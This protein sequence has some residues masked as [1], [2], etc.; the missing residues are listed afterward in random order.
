MEIKFPV[1]EGFNA[2]DGVAEGEKFEFMAEGYFSGS[3]MYLTAVEG[4]PVGGEPEAEP[5]PEDM[6]SQDDRGFVDSV[7]TGLA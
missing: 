7:E 3:T 2:P 4:I 6:E 5:K 1:P